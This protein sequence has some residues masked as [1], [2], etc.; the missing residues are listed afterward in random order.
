MDGFLHFLSTIG[1]VVKDP[2]LVFDFDEHLCFMNSAAQKLFGY[3]PEEFD[4]LLFRDLL[5]KQPGSLANEVMEALKKFETYSERAVVI[6][7]S[8]Q[9]FQLD[10]KAKQLDFE[11]ASY[12][13]ISLRDPASEYGQDVNIDIKAL[14]YKA[15]IGQVTTGLLH[16]IGNLLTSINVSVQN[17]SEISKDSKIPKLLKANELFLEN[18]EN[19][20]KYITEDPA[21]R[22]L[23]EFYTSIGE[24]MQ[25]DNEKLKEELH[26]LQSHLNLIKELIA[27]QQDYARSDSAKRGLSL[28]KLIEAALKI[29]LL[30][31]QKHEVDIVREY[32][33]KVYIYGDKAKMLHVL[34]NITKNAKEAILAS[35]KEDRIFKV[36]LYIDRE[37]NV[38][39]LSLSDNG[40]GIPP[41]LISRMFTYGF[42]TKLDGHGFGLYTSVQ[43]VKDVGGTVEVFSEGAN[44]G[45]EFRLS[46]PLYHQAE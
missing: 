13:V 6:S 40:I 22:Y 33:D 11:S 7:K 25:K 42:T 28:E 10:L 35:G 3:D 18:R 4:S 30:S 16:N 17:M 44:Q 19:I 5:K 46:F 20:E 26:E 14:A 31:F 37:K 12:L 21:G 43:A 41:E 27:A 9:T 1:K 32:R 45:A 15:G 38:G 39:V 36:K 24:F 8:G 29:E 23:P 34:L 2:L